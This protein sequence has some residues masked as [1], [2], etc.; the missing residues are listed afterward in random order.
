M[1][2][3][4]GSQHRAIYLPPR[5]LL[6]MAGPARYQWQHYIPHRK[7]DMVDGMRLPRAPRRVSLTFRQVCFGSSRPQQQLVTKFPE[8]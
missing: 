3:R 5:S 2:M 7:S 8:F 4:L 1:E 6:V